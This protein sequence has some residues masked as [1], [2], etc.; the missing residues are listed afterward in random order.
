[1]FLSSISIKKNEKKKNNRS[2][3]V[4]THSF[5]EESKS[6]IPLILSALPQKNKKVFFMP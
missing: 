5:S 3:A 1:M 2:I 4:M 6:I